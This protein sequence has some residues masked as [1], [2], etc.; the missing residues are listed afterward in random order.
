MTVFVII[1]WLPI[2]PFFCKKCTCQILKPNIIIFHMN[3]A[4]EFLW[5][6]FEFSFKKLSLSLIKNSFFKNSIGLF[7]QELFNSFFQKN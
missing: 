5:P 4:V 6:I 1:E 2:V 3:F 7:L